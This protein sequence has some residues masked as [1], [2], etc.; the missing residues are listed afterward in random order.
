MMFPRLS[1]HIT[2][3]AH[4]SP[5]WGKRVVI[6]R[7]ANQSD[8]L[9]RLLAS[10]GALP[11]LYPCIAIAPLDDPT[12][13]DIAILDAVSGE[14]DTV[15]L[16]SANTVERIDARLR[17]LGIPAYVFSTLRLAAVGAAT[18]QRARELWRA[19]AIALP[20]KYDAR[21]LAELPGLKAGS[22]VFLPQSDR[23]KPTL[24]DGL[25]ARGIAVRTATA[26]RTV[27]GS[28]GARLVP[29]LA[30][31]RVDAVMFASPSAVSGFLDR[32]HAEGGSPSLLDGL[33]ITCIGASTRRAAEDA[34]LSVQVIPPNS[35]LGQWVD[36]LEDYYAAR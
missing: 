34:G 15:I 29:M 8:S 27:T 14:F 33:T 26:Y 11:V 17:A 23:A 1:A 24:A 22:R 9:L 13:L 2:R 10:R 21:S 30:A 35:T 4:R 25:A 31:R 20:E 7:A 32:L 18:A 3:A 36:S 12:P 6:T 28:G 19:E 5:L 16:T